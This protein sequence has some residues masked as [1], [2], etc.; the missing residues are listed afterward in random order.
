MLLNK[1]TY[2]AAFSLKVTSDGPQLFLHA[3]P[4]KLRELQQVLQT[5]GVARRIPDFQ[6]KHTQLPGSK[7]IRLNG[8]DAATMGLTFVMPHIRSVDIE[9]FLAELGEAGIRLPAASPLQRPLQE[10]MSAHV[11]TPEQHAATAIRAARQGDT[12]VL[13]ILIGDTVTPEELEGLTNLRRHY[14]SSIER[15]FADQLHFQGLTL[16]SGT[17]TNYLA[18]VA[19]DPHAFCAEGY[20]RL[21]DMVEIFINEKMSTAHIRPL[22]AGVTLESESD[23]EEWLRRLVDKHL[24]AI[25]TN[26]FTLPEDFSFNNS[27]MVTRLRGMLDPSRVAGGTH[28]TNTTIRENIIYQEQVRIFSADIEEKKAAH[29]V[30]VDRLLGSPLSLIPVVYRHSPAQREAVRHA[31]LNVRVPISTQDEE[32]NSLLHLALERRHFAAANLLLERGASEACVNANNKT[33]YEHALVNR[34]TLVAL[35]QSHRLEGDCHPLLKQFYRNVSDYEH[36]TLAPKEDAINGGARGLYASVLRSVCK[37]QTVTSRRQAVDTLSTLIYF[38]ARNYDLE[39]FIVQVEEVLKGLKSNGSAKLYKPLNKLVGEYRRNPQK[40]LVA[41][42]ENTLVLVS[43]IQELERQLQARDARIGVQQLTI[44]AKEE[45]SS[46]L[47]EQ[48][49]Q[50]SAA[51]AAYASQVVE[52]DAQLGHLHTQLDQK[53]V[54]LEQ[55]NA[56]L[57]QKNVQLGQKEN[58]SQNLKQQ[59]EATNKKIAELC[60]IFSQRFQ[61]MEAKMQQ[62]TADK[63][64]AEQRDNISTIN[65]QS[66]S[67]MFSSSVQM[68]AAAAA[69]SAP[70]LNNG[71]P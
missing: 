1:N 65:L 23:Y 35:R 14:G 40:Y 53:N 32:G 22:C 63:A 16:L 57:E 58:E 61:A 33:P 2:I 30:L 64:T 49:V 28:Q 48:A 59:L 69:A 12:L 46:Q 52:K 66:S 60:E 41:R 67:A 15:A 13:S 68:A 43:Q 54:Q 44:T 24:T 39:T 55:K 37:P 4:D 8:I 5:E 10:L 6:Q 42:T 45:E 27:D 70:T 51:K 3:Y 21:L 29:A 47:R 34:E 9:R 20:Q 26:F 56:Q 31:L 25:L 11:V 7:I 36:G 19:A 38:A 17:L 71:G 62:L 18:K 50:E